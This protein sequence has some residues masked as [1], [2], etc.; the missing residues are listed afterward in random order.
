MGGLGYFP[1][2]TLGNLNAAQLFAAANARPDIAAAVSKADYA[3]LLGWLRENVHRKG[4]VPTP[5][6]IVTAATGSPPSPESH[7]GHLAARYLA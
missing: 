6:E 3:P 7:L 2:Y 1:T 5:A 4:A